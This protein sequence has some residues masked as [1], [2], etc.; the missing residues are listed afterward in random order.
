VADSTTNNVIELVYSAGLVYQENSSELWWYK[1]S[2]SDVWHSAPAPSCPG[3]TPTPIPTSS[4]TAT[5]T[6]VPGITDRIYVNNHNSCP[7]T[8]SATNQYCSIQ[9]A[10]NVAR[11]GTDIRIQNT[12]TT[13]NEADTLSVS[14]TTTN[15]IVI[16]SDD[17]TS[18][19]TLTNSVSLGNNSYQLGLSDTSYVTIQNLKWDGTG[20]NVA[21][22]A[23]HVFTNNAANVVGLNILNN[24]IN[25]W[26]A[27]NTTIDYS[28]HGN[29]AIWFEGNCAGAKTITA[30]VQGNTLTG[31]RYTNL[32]MWCPLNTQ[33]LNNTVSGTV[34]GRADSAA[35]AAGE[36]GNEMIREDCLTDSGPNFTTNTLYRGNNIYNMVGTCSLTMP[37]GGWSEWAGLHVDDG[38]AGGTFEQNQV[39]DLVAGNMSTAYSGIH[40]EQHTAGW[41][42]Q[43]NLFYNF[44]GGGNG[45]ARV[46]Y[47]GP[48]L[49]T[50]G[51]NAPF[52]VSGNT[53]YN[54]T[55]DA[56]VFSMGVTA[57]N[58]IALNNGGAGYAWLE[59]S[60]PSCSFDYN[61]EWDT[62]G[63]AHYG[64]LSYNNGPINFAAW[65]AANPAGTDAH[66]LN[67]NPNLANP[68]AGTVAG[69]EETA[70]SP[71][72][73]AGLT[74]PAITCDYLGMTRTAPY[75]IGAFQ[76]VG[77]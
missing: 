27:S 46:V 72:I 54:T 59:G 66:S 9:N 2:P 57:K 55:Y 64:R 37:S 28:G 50:A 63:G 68:P 36:L 40:L 22:N 30:I 17:H 71:T 75:D 48:A 6:P 26:G 65:K 69:F 23:I 32:E 1:S 4:P 5:A 41:T 38:C 12:G 33:V 31:N 25:N 18:P 8:G 43:N 16:E 74:I 47:I 29:A 15:P 76:G 58:N 7:G 73:G 21:P 42:V 53:V 3:A 52:T 62:S 20:L 67:V 70:S 77:K 49:W 39:H 61:L 56:Y 45:G 34:C 24:T 44:S 51:T 10:L 14:G 13:Y 11:P 60:C 19:P 35:G